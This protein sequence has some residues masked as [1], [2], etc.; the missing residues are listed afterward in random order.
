MRFAL[1]AGTAIFACASPASAAPEGNCSAGTCRIELTPPQL[2][3]AAERLISERHYAEALPLVEALRLAPGFKLQTEFLGGLIAS[4]TGDYAGAVNQFM[5]ILANDPAQTRVRLELAQ[6]LIALKKT[7]SADRQLRIAQQDT[8]LPQQIARTIRTVRDT[9]RSG[10]TWRLD[11][12][13]GIAPDTNINN[14]TSA[15]SVTVLLGDS[16]YQADLND[17]AKANSGVG[18][19]AQLSTGLRLP[20]S[21]TVSALAEFDANGSNYSG[22]QFDDYN[23]QTSAGGEYR[24]TPTSSVSLEGVYARRWF[25]GK[26]ATAQIGARTGGQMVLGKRDRFGYQVD[27]RHVRAYFDRGYDG[28][29]GGLYGTIEHAI[30]RTLVVSAGP[31]FRREW[32]RE[33]AFSNIEVGGNLGVGGELRHGFNIGGSLG[34]SRA[35]FDAPLLIFDVKSRRDTRLV[36]RT[37]LGNRKIRVMG[38]SPQLNWTYNRVSSSIGLYAIKRSRFELTAARYF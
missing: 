8:E 33:D 38:F 26:A 7:A 12:N 9:I 27:V 11:L 35:V 37:T 32:L 20:I 31:F 24:V 22:S 36:I 5:A 23:V 18:L 13:I 10:R 30:A 19:T 17:E 25:G 21:K 16:A 15:Q 14:A 34:M 29:Q 2:L 6:A 1:I 4:R 28:W 3:A